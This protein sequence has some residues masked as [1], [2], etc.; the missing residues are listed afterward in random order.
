MSRDNT[1]P[2]SE[3]F[4]QMIKFNLCPNFGFKRFITIISIIQIVYFFLTVFCSDSLGPLFLAPDVP[5]LIKFGAKYTYA[6]KYKFHIWRFIT[7]LLLHANF[8]HLFSNLISQAIFGLA[9]ETTLGAL[10]ITL[11]YFLSGFGGV[12]LSSLLNDNIAVGASTAVFG[13]LACYVSFYILNWN[14]LAIFGTMRYTFLCIILL[15]MGLNLLSGV[16]ANNTID[17]W[18]HFGGLITGLL[19]GL[20]IINPIVVGEKQKKL[21]F[22]SIIMLSVEMVISFICF[23][24]TADPS[25]I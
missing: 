15:L 13:I 14:E 2:R 24:T 19:L 22:Y 21:R 9:L 11:L 20:I 8:M 7:P 17:N 5:T 3:T 16:V 10:K 12:L 6:M 25:P 23:Y 18:G 1:S 4:F